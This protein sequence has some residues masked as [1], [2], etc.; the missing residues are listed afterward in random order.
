MLEV[1][2]K[3]AFVRQY[4]K[5]SKD[6]QEEIVDKIGLFKSDPKHS[7]LRIHKLQGRLAGR[8]SFSVNYAYRV[9]FVYLSKNKVRFLSVGD[10]DVYKI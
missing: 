6:L 2:Y 10:H 8:Y 1:V 4:K 9:V 7:F 3:P 5:L